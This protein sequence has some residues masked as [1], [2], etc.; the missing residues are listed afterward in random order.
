MRKGTAQVRGGDARY[1]SAPV[2]LSAGAPAVLHVLL[3]DDDLLFCAAVVQM[4]RQDGHSVVACSDVA[5]ALEEIRRH[6]PDLIVT[7]M[8]TPGRDGVQHIATMGPQY[9]DIPLIVL[10]GDCSVAS[11][12]NRGTDPLPCA[13]TAWGR[14]V[15]LPALRRAVTKA[16]V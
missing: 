1:R 2:P 9:G 15:D 16:L 11:D 8:V 14:S 4:L 6:R 5:L 10:A 12:F 3:I 13:M 7:G